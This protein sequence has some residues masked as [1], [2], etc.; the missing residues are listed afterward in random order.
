MFFF[1]AVPELP[2]YID[3]YIRIKVRIL[4]YIKDFQL[5]NFYGMKN[6]SALSK[7]NCSILIQLHIHCIRGNE[8][9]LHVLVAKLC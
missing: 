9:R 6:V 3:L 1:P 2:L 4:N 7:L 5:I 8:L